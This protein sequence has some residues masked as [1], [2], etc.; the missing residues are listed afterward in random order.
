MWHPEGE[1][2]PNS[3]KAYV[4]VKGYQITGKPWLRNIFY[5]IFYNDLTIK[6]K[7]NTPK[8]GCSTFEGFK[9]SSNIS[10]IKK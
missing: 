5:I 6:M 2:F 4:D 10:L 9:R 1:C 3:Q 7:Q 8:K